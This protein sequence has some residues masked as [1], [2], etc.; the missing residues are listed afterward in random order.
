MVAQTG[1]NGRT[2][3]VD[4]EDDGRII[5][6]EKAVLPTDGS[7]ATVRVRA[8][9][10]ESGPRLFKFRVAPQDGEVVPQN[11]AREALMNVRDTRERILYFEGEPRFEMK[12]IRRAVA[13]DKNLLSVAL[14]R[15][16]D[17]K[18]MRLDGEPEEVVGGFPKTRDELFTLPR[19]DPRQR[20]GG[21]VLRRPAADDC[22]LRR[23]ARRRPAD[24]GRPARRS[25]RAATAARRWPTRCRCRSIPRRGRRIRHRWRG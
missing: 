21:R 9:A 7:P 12:F 14:Q 16:A 18:Y 19:P 3:T 5:G 15:T 1:F 17:N 25:A 2:V 22:G 6:S 20:G 13:D 24:A 10:S 23:S 8:V 11:N 4:V